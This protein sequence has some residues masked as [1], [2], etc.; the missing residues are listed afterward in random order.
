MGIGFLFDYLSLN[1]ALIR[2]IY[3]GEEVLGEIS[4]N[5]FFEVEVWQKLL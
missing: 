3:E 4:Q 1:I 5:Y 2:Y